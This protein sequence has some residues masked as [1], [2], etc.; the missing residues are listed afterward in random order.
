MTATFR[1]SFDPF[2][3]RFDFGFTRGGD[4]LRY[5]EWFS[6]EQVLQAQAIHE[7]THFE[8]SVSPVTR[9]LRLLRSKALAVLVE[10]AELA[11]AGRLAEVD[12]TA[13]FRAETQ[14]RIAD[15]TTQALLPIYEGAA[16]MAEFDC[17]PVPPPERS[18]GMTFLNVYFEQAKAILR[19]NR[20]KHRGLHQEMGIEDQL[21]GLILDITVDRLT[22]PDIVNR[23]RT[24]L[25]MP[26]MYERPSDCYLVAWL[27]VREVHEHLSECVGE[28][29]NPC[30]IVKYLRSFFF[31]DWKLV[32]LILRVVR[33][34]VN[35]N[36]DILYRINDR[37]TT[38]VQDFTKVDYD[39]YR[40]EVVRMWDR[41]AD[42]MEFLP[43]ILLD[44]PPTEC[45]D[46]A[47]SLWRASLP[48][49]SDD[50]VSQRQK[51]L[52]AVFQ[53][54]HNR[55]SFLL[56]HDGIFEVAPEGDEIA[57]SADGFTVRLSRLGKLPFKPQQARATFHLAM[58]GDELGRV[59]RIHLA[60]G[61]VTAYLSGGAR[62][63]T[64]A[65]IANA[66]DMFEVAEEST[67]YIESC[68]KMM[69]QVY[70]ER[71]KVSTQ[72]GCISGRNIML[73]FL[74]DLEG[75]TDRLFRLSEALN[76]STPPRSTFS[77]LFRGV[78]DEQEFHKVVTRS[79]IYGIGY[80]IGSLAKNKASKN[81]YAGASSLAEID[82][83]MELECTVGV[84]FPF[85][86]VES[87]EGD[88][89]LCRYYF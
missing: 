61:P 1:A 18:D 23:K 70:G 84:D 40:A 2:F 4:A 10:V 52:W 63:P 13:A 60:E 58:G 79:L 32:D 69:H 26:L 72:E 39:A 36:T 6:G 54:I 56:F 81:L 7:L 71:F 85:F 66:T 75:F 78:F 74:R 47:M 35:N 15:A 9:A 41:P 80:H 12:A 76:H 14:W 42:N 62:M 45:H 67:Q 89:E 27:F 28:N 29:I 31:E 19:E 51:E 87:L 8:F 59:V 16:L 11:T 53:S 43:G 34:D 82:A 83:R 24:L 25:N 55:Q 5:L 38:L 22:H 86:Y 50:T 73:E 68:L 17:A 33:W 88:K 44:I 48:Y 65:L 37:L 77:R 57:M 20:I 64:V 49:P 3:H 46:I 21:E 30:F